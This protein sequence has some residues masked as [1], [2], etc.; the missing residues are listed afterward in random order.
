MIRFH[1]HHCQKMLNVPDES[2]GRRGKCPGCGSEIVVP[3]AEPARAPAPIPLVPAKGKE[4]PK[5]KT[6]KKSQ[7]SFASLMG[8]KK[9]LSN[10]EWIDMTAMVD[11]V[12]FLLIF[13]L[14]TSLVAHQA[15]I[16]F[17]TPENRKENTSAA[18]SAKSVADF[19]KDNEF[20]I[21]RIDAED[22][23]WVDDST[24]PSAQEIVSKLRNAGGAGSAARVLVLA[25]GE[26]HYGASVMV[27]DAAQEA[28]IQ[29]IRLAVQ[30]DEG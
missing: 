23:V 30:D 16:Q 27:L 28:G 3:T 10:E 12:F 17:P 7:P 11:I 19:E 2:V 20:V 5:P 4:K 1:C 6:P 18:T 26:S 21:V 24:A 9:D 25:H 14:V 8:P 15:A 29:D 22:T 13:F